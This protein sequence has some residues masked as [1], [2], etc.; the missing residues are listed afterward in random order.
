MLLCFVGLMLHD[1][2]WGN[3]LADWDQL[4]SQTDF[5]LRISACTQLNTY[6]RA[7]S[8]A[9]LSFYDLKANRDAHKEA[10]W[11]GGDIVLVIDKTNVVEPTHKTHGL[12]SH[13]N[14][15]QVCF[16]TKQSDCCWVFPNTPDERKCRWPALAVKSKTPG[17]NGQPC[18]FSEQPVE[19]DQKAISHWSKFG[20]W[21]FVD[22]FGSGT[23]LIACL[24]ER[25]SCVGT[26]PDP[27]QFK[28]ACIRLD[29]EIRDSL[30][31]DLNAERK[32]QLRAQQLKEQNKRAQKAE[33]EKLKHKRKQLKK[34]GHGA[35]VEEEP[36]S[37]VTP[38]FGL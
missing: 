10:G 7:V 21:I 24:N 2:P 4:M 13:L 16:R 33:T 6:P 14:A 35:T 18:N 28:A 5:N 37:Q 8:F 27:D 9:L 19:I 30:R 34:H 3:K 29:N 22:G 23:S 25:R 12:I 31:F 32:K 26:E 17:V 36:A 11:T 15:A 38:L 1:F 20:D